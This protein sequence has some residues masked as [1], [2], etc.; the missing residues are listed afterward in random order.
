MILRRLHII[1][2]LV[3]LFNPVHADEGMWLLPLIEELKMGRMQEMGL[4]LTA[5]D[6][7]SLN[8]SSLKDMIGALDYGSCT[9]ELISD[10]GLILTNHHCVEDEIQNHTSVE[11]NYLRD[12]FWAQSHEEEL[13]NPGKTISFIVRM[14]NVSER[15]LAMV[16]DEMTEHERE[17]STDEVSREIVK[18]ATEETNYEATVVPFYGGNEYYLVVMETFRDIR[19]VGAPPESIGRFG[20]D[21]D[22]WEWPR[23]NA[24]FSLMRIYTGPDGKPAEYAVENIPYHPE[25]SLPIS[26]EGYNE[27]DFAMVLGF[28][29]RTQRF[30]SAERVR[31]VMDIENTNRIRIRSKALDMIMEEMLAD[32]LVRI[33][34]TAKHSNLSNYYKYALGQN[35]AIRNLGVID[36]KL[37]Q[38]ADLREWIQQD[39]SRILQYGSILDEMTEVISERKEME[40]ALSY[41]EEMFLLYKATELVG[42]AGE[43]RSIY[44][45]ELGYSGDDQKKQELVDELEEAGKVFF[46]DFNAN[47]DKRIAVEMI[48]LFSEQVDPLYYPYFYSTLMGKFDGNIQ[49]YLDHIYQKSFFADS[50]RFQK[51][52][53]K[54]RFRKLKNDPGFMLSFSILSRYISIIYEYQELDDKQLKAERKFISALRKMYPDG[55]FYPDANSTLRLSY[56]KIGGYLGDDAVQYDY[57]TTLSGVLEKE[58]SSTREFYV[59]QLLKD[60]F[61]QKD[62]GP[63]I[64]NDTMPVCFL[65]NNDITGGNSGS[66]VLNTR[67]EIMGLAFDGNWEAMSG[68]ILYEKDKQRCIC[69]DIRYILFLIDQFA[70]ADHLIEEMNI[71]YIE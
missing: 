24:D 2:I 26:L 63:W 18:E 21:I 69:V 6:I 52:I 32:D 71:Q 22:N 27:N 65:T 30:I 43:S 49:L 51:F 35:I 36:R 33:Q 40:N 54:P 20:F 8:H 29:G 37:E 45:Q 14:E 23:H 59:P 42:F 1:L 70:G 19:L 10:E 56:G 38:E 58:D 68:D 31:E 41:M 3:A 39:S 5:D 13:P 12:G 67:G 44:F 53:K 55:V 16:H 25:R 11:H 61:A 9:A 46:K 34:Y 17:E 66:P 4:E 7:Y 28:P 47:L 48:S 64:L 50:L 15:V 60:L 57:T 62:Y